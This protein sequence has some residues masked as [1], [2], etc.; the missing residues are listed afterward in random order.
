MRLGWCNQ[1]SVMNALSPD[2]GVEPKTSPHAI[3][4]AA[5]FG[6]FSVLQDIDIAGGQG[7]I[8]T[9]YTLARILDFE[10]SAF[11]HSATCPRR[12][13]YICQATNVAHP[14]KLGIVARIFI[15]STRRTPLR[16]AAQRHS[17]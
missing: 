6:G 2:N 11:D 8:R 16:D 1:P 3:K 5:Q 15:L 7:E 12:V 4:K 14:G 13:L 10:S 9:H 17:V